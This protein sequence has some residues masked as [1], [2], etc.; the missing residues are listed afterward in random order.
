MEIVVDE[1]KMFVKGTYLEGAPIVPLSPI[2]GEGV[3]RFLRE[4]DK[5]INEVKERPDRGIFRLW[6]DRCF[7]MKGFGLVVAGTVLSG[8]ARLGERLE[9]LPLGREVR[10][11]GL[12]VHN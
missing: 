2:T 4:L 3:E 8:K 6:I 5:L 11:R 7:T 12:Q 1:V 10:V 9:I